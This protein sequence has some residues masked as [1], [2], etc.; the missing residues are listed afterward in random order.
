MQTM[1]RKHLYRIAFGLSIFTILYNLTE[2]LIATYFGYNDKS[3]TLLGFGID[4]FIEIISGFGIAHM[5]FRIWNNPNSSPSD[6]EK[7][8]LRITGY[9]FYTLVIG[10]VIT[11]TYNIWI[12]HKPLNTFWGLIISSISIAIMW[13][14]V[15]TKTKVG[16][17][18]KSEAILADVECTMVCIYMSV[19]LFVSSIIYTFTNMAYIDSIATLLLAYFSFKEGKEC[20][21]KANS[22]KI[23][24]SENI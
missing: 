15:Y 11:S 20:F 16:K 8:A 12:D 1:D 6:F 17:K 2:G 13:F 7:T 23:I 10:L 4:S 21:K 24:I 22:N 5:I 9:A 19:I 14:L 18:L 3:L